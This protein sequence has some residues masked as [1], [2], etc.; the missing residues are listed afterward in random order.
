MAHRFF[1]FSPSQKQIVAHA[2][3]LHITNYRRWMLSGLEMNGCGL[4]AVVDQR[5]GCRFGVFAI[6]STMMMDTVEEEATATG[7]GGARPICRGL[8]SSSDQQRG[9]NG[10]QISTDGLEISPILE[11]NIIV[12][13]VIARLVLRLLAK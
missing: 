6:S 1:H 12:I 3:D 9:G 2:I 5:R 11:K 7:D 10:R 8:L 4:D 13:T